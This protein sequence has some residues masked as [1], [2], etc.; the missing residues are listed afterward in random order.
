MPQTSFLVAV[1]SFVAAAALSLGVAVVAAITIERRSIEAVQGVLAE[2]G[3][4]WAEVGAD[5]LQV[6]LDGVAPD[7]ASR[8]LAE[9]RAST[10]VDASRVVNLAT[11]EPRDTRP[12]PRF[13]LD[14]LRNGEGIQIIGLVPGENGGREVAAAIEAIADG[15]EVTDMV[16]TA[17]YAAPD[18]W[19]FALGYGLRA[20]RELPRSKITVLADRVEV[21]AISD[22][23]EQQADLIARLTAAQPAGIEVDLDISAPRPVIAPYQLRAVFDAEGMRLETCAAE[24][25]EAQARIAAA[26]EAAGVTG[27][28]VCPVGL[29]A[30]SPSWPEAVATGLAM[31]A[32]LGGGTLDFTDA[33]VTLIGVQGTDQDEFDRIIGELDAALPE[34]F[35]LTGTLPQSA[36]L[37]AGPARFFATLDPEEGVSLRG[38]LPEGPV[39]AA[40][41]ALAVAVFGR[42]RTDLATRAVPDLPQGWS[43][44]A[45]AG[46]RALS[47]LHDG[48]LTLEPETLRLRGRTGDQALR[49]ELARQLSEALGAGADFQ[50]DVR[51]DEELDP[52][53]SQLS[54][55]ECVA[56]IVAVQEDDKI[57]FDPGSVEI[58]DAAGAILDRIAEILP[59][60]LHVPMEIGGHTDSQGRE[61]MNLGLSQSRA[62]AVLNG[63]LARG[64]LISNLTA[65]GYGESRPI[66][67][68]GTEDGRELNRRIEFRLQ[69]EVDARD[70]AE[71]EAEAMAA[72]AEAFG[73]RPIPRPDSVVEAAAAAANETDEE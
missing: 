25:P 27:E 14:I 13:S 46:L 60:C 68:N 44:R 8:F 52:V 45:M 5:G 71:A 35:T 33:D 39:G 20:L 72:R 59:D 34:V 18:T 43:I 23:P 12:A 61:D 2:E 4:G 64:V 32:E 6:F 28:I 21:E 65:R 15:A 40:V 17:D 7:E 19:M 55:E 50:L 73:R 54:P 57:V 9:S 63:L 66:A 47:Q 10:V 11:I 29:G 16:E 69:A 56:A 1:L 30:P 62:D 36:T 67:D 3:F 58:S 24:T 49:S 37:G 22:T 48:Q 70:A 41:E 42:E 53:A 51:Y 38:R 26:A 31:L